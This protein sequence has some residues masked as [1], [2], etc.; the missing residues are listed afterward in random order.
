[1]ATILDIAKECSRLLQIPVPSSFYN[2]TSNNQILLKAIIKQ[3]IDELRDE[4]DWPELQRQWLFR[5]I[6][7]LE[8]YPLPGDYDRQITSTLWNR[9]QNWPLIG[10]ID[11]ALWQQYKS[12]LITTLPRQRFRVK[13]IRDNQFYVDPTPTESDADQQMVFEYV[14]KTCIRPPTWAANTAYTTSNYVFYNGLILKCISNGTSANNGQ[15]PQYGI[16][17]TVFWESVPDYVASQVY[18]YGQYVYAN[19]KVYK[20]T[21]PGLSS[22]GAPSVSSGS[23]TLGTV[24]FEYQSGASAWVGGTDYTAGDF[25]SASSH[26]FRCTASGQSGRLSPKFYDVLPT[27]NG[28]PPNSISQ[29]IADG[30]AVWEIFQT[31]YDDFLSDS[32]EVILNNDMVL[33]GARWRFLQAQ[34]L[35]YDDLQAAA[36]EKLEACKTKKE[37]MEVLSVSG[38]GGYPYAIGYW[39]YPQG[40]YAGYDE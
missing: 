36:I 12:G 19:S 15:G 13:G 17:N 14:A 38:R 22:A 7:G 32:D 6:E 33:D 11:P 24:V 8:N 2:S 40:N 27:A 16:D 4:Y 34:R 1:M 30:T 26:A 25:A 31:P 39:S 5:T 23:E 21:T 29:R 28:Y 37:G 9:S 3:T 10:P 20:V 35:P 18:Y